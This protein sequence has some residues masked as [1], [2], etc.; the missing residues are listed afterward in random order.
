MP[1]HLLSSV[2]AVVLSLL[3]YAGLLVLVFVVNPDVQPS[4]PPHVVLV[5]DV[6]ADMAEPEADGMSKID[7]I[8]AETLPLLRSFAPLKPEVAVV[9]FDEQ[10]QLALPLSTDLYALRGAL[11]QITTSSSDQ[12]NVGAA[13]EAA[14]RELGSR[15]NSYIVLITNSA[16]TAGLSSAEIVDGAGKQ[17]RDAGHCFYT[18]DLGGADRAFL[19][20][21]RALASCPQAD[22]MVDASDAPRLRAALAAFPNA[23]GG[24]APELHF[25]ALDAKGAVRI[26][27]GVPPFLDRIRISAFGSATGLELRVFDPGGAQARKMRQV[28]EGVYS[29]NVLGPSTGTWSLALDNPTDAPVSYAL[30]NW[31]VLNPNLQ[32]VLDVKATLILAAV[33]TSLAVIWTSL[34]A[35]RFRLFGRAPQPQPAGPVEIEGVLVNAANGARFWLGRD[36]TAEIHIGSSPECQIRLDDPTVAPR[37]AVI[38]YGKGKYFLQDKAGDERTARNGKPVDAARLVDGDQVGFGGA[39]LRFEQHDDSV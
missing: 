12:A 1:R 22:E 7:I 3:V 35:R 37:H 6:S 18:L 36:E 20:E 13:L 32:K 14:N 33:A 24:M 27:V 31:T 10:V 16:P 19:D 17:A 5:I 30:V 9:T 15:F 29:M 34:V 8:R 25:G 4:P 11:N 26:S 28:R 2:L 39:V 21:L 38:Y 23:I